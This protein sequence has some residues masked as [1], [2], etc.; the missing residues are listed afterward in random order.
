MN[1]RV[2]PKFLDSI[3]LPNVTAY[4]AGSG[5]TRRAAFPRTDLVVFDGPQDDEGEP[6]TVVLPRDEASRDYRLRLGELLRT[7]SVI[8]RRSEEEIAVDLRTPGADRLLARVVSN[9]AGAGSIPLPFAS[10]LL[11]SLRE[12]VVAAACAEEDPRPFF[13]KA[14]KIGTEHALAWRMGQTQ[15][16]SFVVPIEC[17]IAPSMGQQPLPGSSPLSRRVA[18]R[19]MRGL[20]ALERAVLDGEPG[21]LVE[22]YETGLNANMC[23]ALLALKTPGTDLAIEVSA[24]WSKRLP[25]PDGLPERVRVEAKGFELLDATAQALRVPSGAI[26][27]DFVGQI[28]RLYR[29]GSEERVAVLQFTEQGRRMAAHLHLS[30]DDYAIACD[31][32]RD[33]KQVTAHGRLERVS[34]KRWRIL[35]ARDFGTLDRSTD[36][37]RARDVAGTMK[38]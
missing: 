37:E 14:T 5:W 13:A 8:E 34:A 2:D 26:E 27:R 25:A 35:G 24:H 21:A 18:T 31:A 3:E 1:A 29:E 6:I 15:V 32:H 17:A 4:L 20:A 36:A 19:I 12:L 28:V 38:S 22:S 33:S 23:E 7:L 9:A 10:T 11:G 16:G 30:Q